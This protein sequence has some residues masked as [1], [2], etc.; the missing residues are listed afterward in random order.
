LVELVEGNACVRIGVE[1]GVTAQRLGNAFVVVLEDRRK[2]PEEMGCE[3]GA[4]GIWE[5]ERKLFD[6]GNGRHIGSVAADDFRARAAY[7]YNVMRPNL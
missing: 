2:R 7:A 5:I 4:F 3:D 1:F 6:F